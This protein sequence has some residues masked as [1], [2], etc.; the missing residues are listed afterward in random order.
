MLSNPRFH[1][2]QFAHV[3]IPQIAFAQQ[4]ALLGLLASPEADDF[5][6]RVLWRVQAEG[7]ASRA[8]DFD[9]S[10]IKLH[11]VRVLGQPCALL[12][13][14]PPLALTEAY[15]TAIVFMDAEE[16]AVRYFTLERGDSE[17]TLHGT[18]FGEWIVEAERLKHRHLGDGRAP[19]AGEF[20]AD[21]GAMLEAPRAAK[22]QLTLVR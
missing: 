9:A 17:L 19:N 2:Y 3:A 6:A 4:R 15:F 5:I 12:E 1:H 21:I 20:L 13:M 14:P 11:R 18:V 7:G 8:L 22:A 10:E 16:S